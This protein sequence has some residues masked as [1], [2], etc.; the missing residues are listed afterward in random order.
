MQKN[1]N[2]VYIS[3]FK[4]IFGLK[5][6]SLWLS[7]GLVGSRQCSSKFGGRVGPSSFPPQGTENCA[8]ESSHISIF[9][10]SH[11]R[12]KR[13]Q[14][15][16]QCCTRSGVRLSSTCTCKR[17]TFCVH[18]HNFTVTDMGCSESQTKEVRFSWRRC[19][20]QP[21]TLADVIAMWKHIIKKFAWK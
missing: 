4:K 21:L 12:L 11:R 3:P 20:L 6:C 17:K 13:L 2:R 18:S 9:G 16:S 15:N 1:W 19:R 7:N 10:L 14:V 5:C 8:P